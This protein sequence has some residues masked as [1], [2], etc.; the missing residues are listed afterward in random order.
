MPEDTKVDK[1]T[2]MNII[3][4]MMYYAK[5]I[6]VEKFG[7][8]LLGN[9]LEV[10]K[11]LPEPSMEK[12]PFYPALQYQKKF[13]DLNVGKFWPE[14]GAFY[15]GGMKEIPE[16]CPACHVGKM[17]EATKAAQGIHVCDSCNIGIKKSGEAV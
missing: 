3:R 17:V 9:Q 14:V 13:G 10:H 15:G 4:T 16:T 12:L 6:N 11:A 7:Q 5:Y 2:I 1:N 8:A